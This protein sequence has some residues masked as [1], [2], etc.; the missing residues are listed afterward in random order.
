MKAKRITDKKDGTERGA[1]TLCK[2]ASHM[3][4]KQKLRRQ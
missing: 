2:S 1:C 4:R 3:K